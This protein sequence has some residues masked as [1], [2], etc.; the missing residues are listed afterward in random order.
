[1]TRYSPT[2]LIWSWKRNRWNSW[3]CENV[4]ACPAEIEGICGLRSVS[5]LIAWVIWGQS[6]SW[7]HLHFYASDVCG[8][9]KAFL[10]FHPRVFGSLCVW[11]TA[12]AGRL[13]PFQGTMTLISVVKEKYYFIF[14][15]IQWLA[16]S[17]IKYLDLF[18]FLL[19]F[20]SKLH[21][22]QLWL[23]VISNITNKLRIAPSGS[24]RNPYGA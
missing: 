4:L 3:G 15:L 18:M 17:D 14:F 16:F 22:L 5:C 19:C 1:M 12:V 13:E 24:F 20:V 8:E 11:S 23:N 7:L 2:Q 21:V 10:E 9:L 6:V